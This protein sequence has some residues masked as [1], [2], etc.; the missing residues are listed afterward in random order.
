MKKTSDSTPTCKHPFALTTYANLSEAVCYTCHKTF[1][2]TENYELI[3]RRINP[4]ELEYYKNP[5]P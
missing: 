3:E 4:R 5:N 2:V 1:P